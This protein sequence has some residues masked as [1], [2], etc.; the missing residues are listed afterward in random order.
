MSMF[1]DSHYRWRETYF[2]LFDAKKRPSVERVKKIIESLKDHFELVNL[3]GDTEHRF[4]SLSVLA[5]DDFAALDICFIGGDEVREQAA[6]LVEEMK[7][8]ALEP[9]DRQKLKQISHSDGRFDVLHFEQLAERGDEGDED[10]LL[11]PSAVLLVLDALARLTG[12]VAVDPQ[13]GTILS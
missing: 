6:Q 1:E 10:E 13:S 2:V 5:P 4:E 8:G 9:G 7:V 11:D 3:R 12:G